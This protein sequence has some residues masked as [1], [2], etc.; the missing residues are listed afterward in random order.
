MTEADAVKL[1]TDLKAS[2]P[3][4]AHKMADGILLAYLESLGHGPVTLAYRS[5]ATAHGHKPGP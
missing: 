5:L 1:L 3:V 4:T 2:D